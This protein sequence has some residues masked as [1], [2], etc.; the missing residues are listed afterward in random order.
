MLFLKGDFRPIAC[1]NIVNEAHISTEMLEHPMTF[2]HK[3]LQEI[4]GH[5][6]LAYS[7]QLCIW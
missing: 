3:H 5:F 1:D 4:T 7:C 6:F 2:S